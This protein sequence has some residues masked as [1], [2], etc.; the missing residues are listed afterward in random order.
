MQLTS[1]A[2]AHGG[3]IPAKYTCDGEGISLPLCITDVPHD[4]AGLV[5]IMD[6]PDLPA[7]ARDPFTGEPIAVWDHWVVFN[8]PPHTTDVAEGH[9]P[10]GTMGQNTRGKLGYSAPCPPDREHR[11][12][13][14]L[15]ALDYLLSLPAGATKHD[16][17]QSMQGHVI[18]EAELIGRYD[19]LR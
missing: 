14:K 2:F 6:D 17:E 13:F 10:E 19:R 4:A 15:Y 12:F 3:S 8:I 1:T 9:N 16:V 18:A 7:A 5:L 11:Y